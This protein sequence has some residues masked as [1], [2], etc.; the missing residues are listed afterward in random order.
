MHDPHEGVTPTGTITTGAGRNRITPTFQPVLDAAAARVRDTHPGASL[1]VYGSVATGMARLHASDVDLL[2]I[3]LEPDVA[4]ALG[5]D[6]SQRFSDVCRAVEL[7]A[8]Q[9]EDFAAATDAGYGGRV[10]LRHYCV[11]LAGP[12]LSSELPA[13]PADVRAARAFNGDIAIHAAQW[14]RELDAGS[15][16][17]PLGRRV[18]RKTLLAVAGLVSVHDHTWTTDRAASASRWSE[19]EPN[20]AND[21][22]KL[23]SWSDG[24]VPS[25]R[26]SVDAALHGVVARVVASFESSIGLWD[27]E[28]A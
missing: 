8:A 1:Y 21:L 13:F 7:S 14:R 24:N 4:A 10:F 6:L 18:A 3:G 17:E 20:L 15:N 2:T 27:S 23:M 16:P 28:V 9:P 25:S 26:S 11:H 19:V 22:T 12:D 5:R